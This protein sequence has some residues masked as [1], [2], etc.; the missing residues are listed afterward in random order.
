M[1]WLIFQV[2]EKASQLSLSVEVRAGDGARAGPTYGSE[3]QLGVVEVVDPV[4]IIIEEL[5]QGGAAAV[6]LE[7]GFHHFLLEKGG[8]LAEE[9]LS[10]SKEK[11]T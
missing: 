7:G 10:C 5:G 8:K 9:N 1:L 6:G 4:D 3:M 2:S 11:L